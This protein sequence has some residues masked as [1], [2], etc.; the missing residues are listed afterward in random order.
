MPGML[1]LRGTLSAIGTVFGG[2][3]VFFLYCSFIRAEMAVYALM[4]LGTAT[5][6]AW[7]A[8]RRSNTPPRHNPTRQFGL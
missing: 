8:P 3:G 2:L 4:F 7:Y 5:A 6:I 1:M